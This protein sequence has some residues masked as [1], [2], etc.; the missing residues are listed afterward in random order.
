M[1]KLSIIIPVY[2]TS[3]HLKKCINSI[4]M[5]KLDDVEI[6]VINDGSTDNS[7]NILEEYVTKNSSKMTYYEKQN[8]GVADTRN[9]GIEKAN[10]KYILFIDSDDYIKEGLIEEL[11]KY[12]DEDIDIIKYKLKRVNSNEET[13]EK[14]DGP[15]FEKVD[16][17]TAFNM[18]CFSDVLLDS[19]CVYVFKRELFIQNNLKF[20]TNTEHEDFGLIPLIIT[21]AKTVVSINT[22]GYCY[23][24]TIGS[25]TRNEDYRK[26]IKKI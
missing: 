23:L 2:N 10:G 15:V 25:I 20:K 11:L 22:Y 9:F 3:A 5:Q 12:I 26:N 17:Q 21:K 8:R 19:P 7:K 13:I 6:L 1:C 24:Q 18:L 4:L 14:I 16:G